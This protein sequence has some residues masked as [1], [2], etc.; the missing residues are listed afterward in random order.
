MLTRVADDFEFTIGTFQHVLEGYKVADRLKEHGAHASTFSDWWAYKY[1]VIDA[2]P[3]NGALMTDVGVT[4]SFNSDSRE[5]ARRMNTEAAKGVKY[6]GLSEVEALKLVT[7]NPAI[8]LGIDKWVGS[9]EVGK[10]ADFVIWNDHPLSTSTICEQT[11]IDGIQY[12]SRGTD[13]QLKQRDTALRNQLV[14]K[15]LSKKSDEKKKWNHK[16][17]KSADHHHCL[18]KL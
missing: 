14:S 8:Q 4:V 15:I 6:G 9:L 1:E 11:W 7:L 18:E 12:F 3:Y 2:I 10:D 13:N 5:L 16:E 17:E